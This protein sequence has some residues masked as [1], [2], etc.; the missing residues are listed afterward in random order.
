MSKIIAVDLGTGNSCVSVFQNGASYVIQNSEGAR[1]TPSIVAFTKDHQTYVGQSAK[2]Q[3]VTNPE[4]TIYSIKRLMGKSYKQAKN[5][6]IPYKLVEDSNGQV[7]VHISN[8]NKDYTPQQISALILKKMKSTAEDYLGEPVT[9]AVI[10]VPAYFGDDQRTATK[11]AG[12]IA[13]L[14][15]L[16]IINEPT[17]AALAYGVDSKKNEKVAVYDFGSGTFDISILDISGGIIE[18]LSTNGDTNLGGDDIDN[19]LMDWIVQEFKNNEGIDLSKDSMALQRIKE[20][21]EKAKIELSGTM[22]TTIN[23]PFITADSNGPKHLI[24]D[25][26]RA[27]FENMISEI[28][29]RT[30]EPCNIALKDAKLNAADIS[31]VLLVG[32]STRIPAVQ[33]AVKKFFGKEPNKSLNPD[34]VVSAGAAIQAGILSGDD[35]VKDVL[36]LDVTPLSL[37]IETLGNVMTK[38]I[39]KNTT[40]PTKKSQIFSTAA[41][42]QSAVT[43]HVLQGERPM[44]ADNKSLGRFDLVDIPPAPRG[45]PQ[46]EV[47]FDIDSNGIIH[48]S[49]TDKGTGKQQSIK[50][51]RSGQLSESDIDAMIKDAELHAAEDERLREFIQEKNS[52][53]SLIFQS[54][55]ALKQN[56]DKLPNDIVTSVE[57]AIKETKQKV[58]SLKTKEECI[59]LAESFSKEVGKMAEYLYKTQNQQQPAEPES[60]KSTDNNTIDAEFEVMD[61]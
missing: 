23:L 14:E 57:A 9:Q 34:E 40:I 54:E 24:M 16:R 2:R 19:I 1:T 15:V 42:N 17:A 3:A 13:G 22:S 44:S 58:Q 46:I 21:A 11:D 12:R 36:L 61:N 25:L 30:I 43:I 50:I 31:E 56:R 29:T 37:G 4:N 55:T 5:E 41:D 18:V 35:N 45:I 38:I 60:N 28:I 52:L 47:V 59:T 49:A 6:R 10:T 8:D 7:R 51:E 53:Q 48:V 33:D 32:G 39:E 20:S 27:K 26:S